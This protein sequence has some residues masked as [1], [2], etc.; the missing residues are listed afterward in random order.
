MTSRSPEAEFLSR[1]VV[2][3]RIRVSSCSRRH[4]LAHVASPVLLVQL[5]ALAPSLA[6]PDRLRVPF[7]YSSEF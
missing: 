5:Q 6:L 7:N 2:R 4:A 3:R 1:G